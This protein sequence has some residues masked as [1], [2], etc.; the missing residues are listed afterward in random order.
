MKLLNA[1]LL[2]TLV[3]GMTAV[4]KLFS[5]RKNKDVDTMCILLVVFVMSILSYGFGSNY[6][7]ERGSLYWFAWTA[8]TCMSFTFSKIMLGFTIRL[9]KVLNI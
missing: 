9:A 8:I 5:Y 6:V 4:L 7:I 2:I 1:V 3:F